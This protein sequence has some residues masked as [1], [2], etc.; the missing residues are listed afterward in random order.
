[1]AEAFDEAEKKKK[2]AK[3][4]ENARAQLKKAL[5]LKEPEPLKKLIEIR[6]IRETAK[7]G[8]ELLA[9]RKG[10]FVEPRE[11]E[12]YD[13]GS[14]ERKMPVAPPSKPE[15]SRPPAT[16]FQK[17]LHLKDVQEKGKLLESSEERKRNKGR[18]EEMMRKMRKFLK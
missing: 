2:E 4:E 5:D 17:E 3:K 9:R 13:K 18:F 15:D 12:K 6:E 10:E 8:R 1:M 11:D 7:R 14:V 16:I